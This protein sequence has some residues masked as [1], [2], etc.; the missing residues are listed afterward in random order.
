MNIFT[1]RHEWVLG[2][3]YEIEAESKEE[4]MQ[5]LRAKID[6]GEVCVYT[7]GYETTDEEHVFIPDDVGKE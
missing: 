1:V 3:D 5:K 4:A 7:D 2:K 6:A